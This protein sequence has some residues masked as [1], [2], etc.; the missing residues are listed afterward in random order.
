MKSG[1]RTWWAIGTLL[2][3]ALL[4]VVFWP[5]H[6]PIEW[7]H[8]I[9]YNAMNS[10]TIAADGTIYIADTSG[11]LT[12]LKPD[13]TLRWRQIIGPKPTV[14]RKTV[15]GPAGE[16]YVPMSGVGSNAGLLSVDAEDGQINWV[17]R[18]RDSVLAP[19]VIGA[20]ATVY[21]GAYDS[22]F[23]ALNPDGSE[24]W[25]YPTDGK[26]AAGAIVG[27]EGEVIFVSADHH[28]HALHPNGALKWKVHLGSG[29]GHVRA[30]AL[31]PDGSVI[32]GAG[33]NVLALT[34]DGHLQWK[35]GL[36]IRDSAGNVTGS[37]HVDA[38]PVVARDGGIYVTTSGGV[39]F[40]LHPSGSVDWSF[41]KGWTRASG[42]PVTILP[43]GELLLIREDSFTYPVGTNAYR[44]GS[45]DIELL[46]LAGDG[47][48]KKRLKLPREFVWDR[49]L[50]L[51][52]FKE[53][54]R[55]RF[56]LRDHQGALQPVLG[57]NGM[58][59]IRVQDSKGGRLYAI[60]SKQLE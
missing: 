29:A 48:V 7:T 43:N 36:T 39:L 8:A 58:I 28:C 16:I 4:I 3:T 45:K 21:F 31:A 41:D 42:H 44:D 50:D 35:T 12:A 24:R 22:N 52:R 26:I 20:D 27:N 18:T 32:L 11:N 40:R 30:P 9:H 57:S 53:H 25:S 33:T 13:G 17:F 34:P 59:H 38:S 37:A 56:G 6:P 14:T 60:D 46:R 54:R 1:K 51:S 19:P 5:T 10:P 55:T 15:V 49:L 2:V 23:Y 47:S